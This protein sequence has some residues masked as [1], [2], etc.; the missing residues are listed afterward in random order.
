M[1]NFSYITT[2]LQKKYAK[3]IIVSHHAPIPEAVSEQLQ[4]SWYAA[5]YANNLDELIKRNSINYWI[6]GH[7]HQYRESFRIHDTELVTNPCG[8]M[9]KKENTL[10]DPKRVIVV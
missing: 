3:R 8:Y 4:N 5:L 6:Y 9:S 7:S 10:F 1:G 2:E